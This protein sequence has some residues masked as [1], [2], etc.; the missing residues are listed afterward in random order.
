M[1]SGTETAWLFATAYVAGLALLGI[2]MLLRGRPSEVGGTAFPSLLGTMAGS[3]SF[4]PAVDRSPERMDY[5]IV[6]LI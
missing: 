4:G 2:I 3:G 5:S 1:Q 6:L